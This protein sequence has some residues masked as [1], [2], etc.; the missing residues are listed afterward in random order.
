MEPTVTSDAKNSPDRPSRSRAFPVGVRPAALSSSFA[1]W[2]TS[3][4]D[5]GPSSAASA[6]SSIASS[7]SAGL[8]CSRNFSLSLSPALSAACSGFGSPSPSSRTWWNSRSARRSSSWRSASS[9]AA[10]RRKSTNWWCTSPV[11]CA[12]DRLASRPIPALPRSGRPPFV[13]GSR[14]RSSAMRRTISGSISGGRVASCSPS[15]AHVSPASRSSTP[16]SV[17]SA[18]WKTGV[19]ASKPRMVAAQPRWVSRIWPTFIRDGTPNGLR[20]MSTGLPSGRNGMSSSGTMRAMMPL[21]PWRPAI[22]SPTEIL[23]FSAT[24]TFTSWI[25][26]GG[27]SSG[28]RILSIWSSDFSSILARSAAAAS[29]TARIRSFTGLLVTRSVFRSTSAKLISASCCRDSFV[30]CG[31]YSSTVPALSIRPTSC[32]AS[33]SRSSA[34]IASEMRA[35]SSTSSRRTSPM[36]SPR[37]F[38][39]TWSSMREKIFTSMTTPSIPGGTLSDESFTSFAF[40]PK[41]AVRSFSSGL[42][43]VS[44]LGVIL[45][46]RMSPAL[47]CA[48]IR[49]MPRS[50]RST[51]DSSAT[52]G[53]SRVISSRPRLVSD[54][55]LELLNVDRRIHVVLHQTLRQDDR[56]LEVVP[57]PGH[58]RDQHVRAHRQLTPLGAC[59]VGHDLPG[60][61]L[62]VHVHQRPLIDG[63][64]L[65]GAPE[66]LQAVAVV[67]LEPRE[68]VISGLRLFLARVD[69]DLVGGD[70][71]DHTCP[72]G[73]HHG[74]RVAGHGLL[75]PGPH[76]RGLRE[77]E[78][79]RLPLH[80]RAHERAVRVVVLE[81]RNQRRGDRH[82]LFGRHVHEVDPCRRQQ[83]V[84]VPLAAQHQLV[85]EM[86]VLGEARVGLR[87]GVFLFLRGR[88]PAGFV[89]HLAAL[90]HAVR[91]L[92]EAEVVH[93]RVAGEARDEPDV[94]A[95]RRLDGTHAPVLA[96]VHIAH[97]EAGALARESPR[98]QGREAPLVRQ[99][100]QWVGLIHELRQLRAAEERLDH[101][102]HRPGVHQVVQGDP[103]RIVVDAHPLL[104]EPRHAGQAHR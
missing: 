2:S 51:S 38:S 92:Y 39:T 17:S 70:P 58:E 71:G 89:G 83:G 21:F 33:S 91:R 3:A 80:V 102:A 25:T 10:A 77:E 79:Y 81:E 43:S 22:L 101:R 66:L 75:E 24:Y 64:V 87:H 37:S 85:R 61:H 30:P 27:S 96:V 34:N 59:T 56:V 62:L 7:T 16:I 68:G 54:V 6:G 29:S 74:A 1:A 73:D 44:P 32:P 20:T 41:M 95:F 11:S 36:R 52:F 49:T 98:S 28:W 46:T 60:L 104:D 78:R 42:S 65:V 55:E 93:A 53:I 100:G 67:L 14:P 31:R 94:R 99:L 19:L 84:V 15:A 76:E 45:P 26:P 13:A 69:D 23:R 35:F 12:S 86:A 9:L 8:S 103:L 18:P 48:P 90:H 72:P 47:T 97:L 40:S 82:E 5:L 88:Q 57:V 50:S 4:S 63:R